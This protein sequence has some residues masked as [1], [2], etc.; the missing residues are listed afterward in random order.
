MSVGHGLK[1]GVRRE[2][3]ASKTL[4]VPDNPLLIARAH[5]EQL[6]SRKCSGLTGFVKW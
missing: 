1:T 6:S 4:Q 2:A 3:S 5:S